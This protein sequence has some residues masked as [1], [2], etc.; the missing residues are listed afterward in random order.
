ML[1]K[2]EPPY[3]ERYVRWCERTVNKLIIY[4]LLDY[5]FLLTPSTTENGPYI[6]KLLNFF[7]TVFLAP[8]AEELYFR[9]YLINRLGT[10]RKLMSA[11]M[12]SSLL[13]SLL[14]V[15]SFFLPQFF[16]GMIYGLLYIKTQKLVF[17]MIIHSF[18]NFLAGL[19]LLLP[20][21]EVQISQL[22]S[23]Q[24]IENVFQIGSH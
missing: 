5:E 9:G 19:P 21:T 7:V 16:S 8:V 1:Y 6:Y 11:V 24:T 15:E 23:L 2:I 14:H 17:P 3:T 12:I 4:L 10:K 13:F 18:H 20:E 22:P